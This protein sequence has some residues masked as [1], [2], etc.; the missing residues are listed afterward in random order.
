MDTGGRRADAI[1]VLGAAVRPDGRPGQALLRRIRHAVA[2][3]AA[4]AA[5]RLILC[6]A[7]RHGAGVSEAAAMRE[8][9]LAAGVPP[10]AILLDERSTSTLGNA[11]ET[12][13]LLRAHGLDSVILVSDAF[14]L[15]RARILFRLHGVRVAG[16]S[17]AAPGPL[18]YCLRM[19]LREVLRIPVVLWHLAAGRRRARRG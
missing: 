11:A 7:D 14:H 15:P 6:G 19:A 3:H 2:L 8:V 9:A 18:P 13:A 12:A 17:A 10:Q 4:G 1:V 5:P 16:V